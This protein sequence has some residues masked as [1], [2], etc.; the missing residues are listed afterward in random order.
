MRRS[1]WCRIRSR[2]WRQ[3]CGPRRLPGR[4]AAP[5]WTRGP[6]RSGSWHARLR[7][8]PRGHHPGSS[9]AS[10]GHYWRIPK[11]VGSSRPLQLGRRLQVG[12]AAFIPRLERWEGG[13]SL[14]QVQALLRAFGALARSCRG[15]RDKTAAAL[16]FMAG[17]RGDRRICGDRT[18]A[19]PS[20]RLRINT[21]P[22]S[23]GTW[24]A[25]LPS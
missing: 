17:Q 6:C 22:R 14:L 24:S 20:S 21:Q 19:A 16:L 1:R 8:P 7:L 11:R 13:S 12:H 25:G 4:P 18:E 5:G 3:I 2:R 9:R 10:A 15:G 23:G